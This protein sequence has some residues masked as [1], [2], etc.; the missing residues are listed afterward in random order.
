MIHLPLYDLPDTKVSTL[1]P[2]I[3]AFTKRLSD[4]KAAVDRHYL[5]KGKWK[6]VMRRLRFDRPHLLHQLQE[7]GYSRIEFRMFPVQS[8]G[9]YHEFM[10]ATK[11]A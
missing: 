6:P 9:S 3:I 7:V 4:L 11:C 5:L 2:P 1:F 8:N 10:F